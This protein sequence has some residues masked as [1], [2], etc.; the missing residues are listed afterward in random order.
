MIEMNNYVCCFCG[1]KIESGIGGVTA[2]MVITN[3]EKE[4]DMQSNQA[5][6]CH[7]ECLKQRLDSK[8]HFLV[9]DLAVEDK[10]RQ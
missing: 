5:L 1:E 3:W 10:E 9:Y 8:T 7:L 2:L 4:P 6:Y